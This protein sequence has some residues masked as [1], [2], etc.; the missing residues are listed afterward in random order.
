MSF[1]CPPKPPLLKG[2]LLEEGLNRPLGLPVQVARY[3]KLSPFP[4]WSFA[5]GSSLEATK[6]ISLGPDLSREK[7]TT[8]VHPLCTSSPSYL[9]SGQGMFAEE[10]SSDLSVCQL[11]CRNLHGE[12]HPHLTP[13]RTREV[14]KP[15]GQISLSSE[16]SHRSE[17]D[18]SGLN[19]PVDTLSFLFVS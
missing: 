6:R 17:V 16:I 12:L 18:T 14:L 2:R 4:L 11:M 8:S 3:P 10:A 19:W 13:S 7:A 5:D 15:T 9:M 1:F